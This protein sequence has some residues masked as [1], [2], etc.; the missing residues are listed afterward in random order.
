VAAPTVRRPTR[1]VSLTVA[2]AL[3]WNAPVGVPGAISVGISELIC[4]VSGWAPMSGNT[5]S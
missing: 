2:T 5:Q 1:A 4:T 3:I